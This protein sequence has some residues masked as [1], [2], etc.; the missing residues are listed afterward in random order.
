[1]IFAS[2]LKSDASLT[3]RWG[4]YNL[5]LYIDR[6]RSNLSQLAIHI[7]TVKIPGIEIDPK[8]RAFDIALSEQP[9]RR[10]REPTVIL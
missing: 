1:M 5:D 4:D 9:R 8:P 10:L 2:R 6:I 3:P 7:L